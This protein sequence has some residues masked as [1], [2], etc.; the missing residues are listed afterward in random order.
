MIAELVHQ[1]YNFRMP[2]KASIWFA[3]RNSEP[4]DGYSS[5]LRRLGSNPS[6]NLLSR[7]VERK[8]A[9]EMVIV[10]ACVHQKHSYAMPRMSTL[11]CKCVGYFLPNLIR[12]Q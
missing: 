10:V 12:I 8:T 1:C 2:K 6:M 11:T 5:S 9:R 4:L 7:D 3:L